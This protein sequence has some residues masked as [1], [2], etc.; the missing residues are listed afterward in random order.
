MYVYPGIRDD[1]GGGTAGAGTHRLRQLRP[2]PGRQRP[3]PARR[4]R[5]A[6]SCPTSPPASAS[7]R[8]AG[9]RKLASIQGVP[10]QLGRGIAEAIPLAAAQP[11][12]HAGAGL[13]RG[14]RRRARGKRR[15]E[16]E[17]LKGWCDRAVPG[18]P[19]RRLRPRAAAVGHGDRPRQVHRLPG[20]RDRLLRGEQHSDRGRDRDP[21]GPGDDLD[22]HRALLGGRRAPGE[23][24]SAR[25]MPML[26]QHCANAPCEPVCPVYAAY[27]TP[28]A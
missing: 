22:P 14:G 1:V 18:H 15:A 21:Q 8:P 11:G 9:F 4:A 19:P 28:T 26:C 3:R 7:A 5:A 2:G 10:R 12:P 13:P 23:P 24:V 6:T 25:F 27:H 17:A 20:L 16:L